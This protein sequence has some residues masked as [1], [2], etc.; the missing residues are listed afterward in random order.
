[1]KGKPLLLVVL[2]LVLANN[3]SH[4]G[5]GSGRAPGAP[6]EEATSPASDVL[7]LY[8]FLPI[9]AAWLAYYH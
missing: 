7:L 4:G 1:M 2:I 9:L 6:E 5:E 8:V 3:C